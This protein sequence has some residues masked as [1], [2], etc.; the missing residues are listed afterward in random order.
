MLSPPSPICC[1]CAPLAWCCH[2]D[3][4][5]RRSQSQEVPSFGL[6]LGMQT[7]DGLRAEVT[8]ECSR[9]VLHYSRLQPLLA[10]ITLRHGSIT[11]RSFI[12]NLLSCPCAQV[13]HLDSAMPR[14]AAATSTEADTGTAAAAVQGGTSSSNKA[15][16][17]TQT[18]EGHSGAVLC[19]TWNH[20][21]NK[22]TT[23]D[24]AGL[25]IVWSL[26]ND[27]WHEEMINNR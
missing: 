13:L 15:L 5:A 18:L 23:S 24:E 25:I 9:L 4:A 8:M 7:Q 27:S 3:A 12:Q 10:V 21:H 19:A 11:C 6:L 16:S 1:C 22:L 20:V 2:V 17:Q 14:Q 26:Q